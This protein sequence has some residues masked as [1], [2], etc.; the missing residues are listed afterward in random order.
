MKREYALSVLGALYYVHMMIFLSLMLEM[1]NSQNNKNTCITMLWCL[2]PTLC[3]C[4]VRTYIWSNV[5][6]GL[7]VQTTKEST[8]KHVVYVVGRDRQRELL[9]AGSWSSPW[10]LWEFLLLLLMKLIIHPFVPWC[11][12]ILQ[13]EC[14][15]SIFFSLYFDVHFKFLRASRLFCIWY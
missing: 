1:N 14:W 3:S 15:L 6:N 4:T 12:T 9:E 7:Y 13:N 2:F 11:K 5:L 10:L 8:H